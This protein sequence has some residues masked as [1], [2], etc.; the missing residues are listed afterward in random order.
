M[1]HSCLIKDLM[2]NLCLSRPS[3][4]AWL[5]PAGGE[6]VHKLWVTLGR[7][8]R[9]RRTSCPTRTG[10]P[11]S[12]CSSS[13]ASTKLQVSLYLS[14]NPTQPNTQLPKSFSLFELHFNSTKPKKTCFIHQALHRE[15]TIQPNNFFALNKVWTIK[16]EICPMSKERIQLWRSE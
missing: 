15:S 16:R 3:R 4:I 2:A 5:R 12:R 14:S 9:R 13:S 6:A 11:G 10:N 7:R 1:I 8:R